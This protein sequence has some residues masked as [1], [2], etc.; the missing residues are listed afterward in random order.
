[1]FQRRNT[2]ITEQLD[3]ILSEGGKHFPYVDVD[4]LMGPDNLI[5]ALQA[6]GLSVEEI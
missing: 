1:M 5:V 2:A 6:L 3:T 4:R